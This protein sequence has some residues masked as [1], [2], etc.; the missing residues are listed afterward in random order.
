M[1]KTN[2]L[3]QTLSR[4]SV[5]RVTIIIMSTG[6]TRLV[7]STEKSI[8]RKERPA[9]NDLPAGLRTSLQK[10]IIRLDRK[11]RG[12]K[13]VTVIEGLQ[14]VQQ[15][16][17]MLLKRLKTDIGTGGTIKDRTLELQGDHCGTVMAALEK[18]GHRPKGSGG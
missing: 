8:S 10:V 17:E 7:Y 14:M 12:G 2:S 18:L 5:C 15:E 9:E 4:K 16:K 3:R 11:G 13:S 6:N 1:L